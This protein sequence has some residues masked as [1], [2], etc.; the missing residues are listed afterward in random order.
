MGGTTVLN[1]HPISEISIIKTCLKTSLNLRDQFTGVFFMTTLVNGLMKGLFCLI[2]ITLV[3]LTVPAGAREFRIG[4]LYWSMNIPGQVAMRNGL[5]SEVKSINKVVLK[6]GR[7]TV[8]LEI[9]VAGDGEAGIK[10]QI[11]QMRELIAMHVDLIIVQ[12]TDNAAL[13]ASLRAAN[14]ARIPVV[15]YDQYISGGILSAYRTSDNYQAGYLDGEYVSSLFPNGKEIRLILVEYPH[16][17]STVERVNGFLDALKEAGR[18]YKVLKSYSAVEP[19]SGRKAASDILR[20]FPKKG[21]IDVIFT[22]ND[23]GGLS[24]VDGLSNAG[25]NEIMVATI[26]GDP[27]S[28]YNIRVG[29]LTVIDSAQFCGPL[30]AEAMKA[31]YALLIGHT[32]PFH[33]LVPVFPVTRRTLDLYPG[34]QGPIPASFKKPWKS[35]LPKW[36]RNLSIVKP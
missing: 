27:A 16:V 36:Q 14:K 13:A 21:S 9:R 22:V 7:P 31:A 32:T 20:D 34:W 28:I 3:L 25:R 26:D 4:V 17:S 18:R 35:K 5:E 6:D 11:Q 30:G 8:K 23:G 2:V 1:V 15:A 24:V 29:R 10:N 19:V 33:A 12:P